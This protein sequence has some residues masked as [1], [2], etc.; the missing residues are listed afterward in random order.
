MSK[1]LNNAIYLHEEADSLYK[2]VMSMYTDKNHLRVSDPGQVEGNMVFSYL[3]AF[4]SDKEKVA[5]F[6]RH[7]QAGGLG[8]TV[9]KKYLFEVLNTILTPIRERRKELAKNH[10]F[11]MNILKQGSQVARSIATDTL[12]EVRHAIGV[13]YF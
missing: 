13:D 10:D 12:T 1:S 2:K 8:D 3:D 7:Y 6:K 11:I 4:D 5:E 9:L